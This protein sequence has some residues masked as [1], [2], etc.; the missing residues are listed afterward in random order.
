MDLGPS[1]RAYETVWTPELSTALAAF[2]LTLPPPLRAYAKREIHRHIDSH[3]EAV[4][5]EAIAPLWAEIRGETLSPSGQN[6]GGK[7]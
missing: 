1:R 5:P 6:Q 4:A 7:R 3:G 2:L